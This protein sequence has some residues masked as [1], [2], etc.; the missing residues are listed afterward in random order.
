[1]RSRLASDAGG[2]GIGVDS[3][4]YN[5]AKRILTSALKQTDTG[6]YDTIVA[7]AKGKFKG[8]S[9]ILFDLKNGGVGS[10][11]SIPPC[12]RRGSC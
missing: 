6:V 9:D 7:A 10:A 12:R 2:Y 1:M 3:D 5:D 4:E 11:R 8:G